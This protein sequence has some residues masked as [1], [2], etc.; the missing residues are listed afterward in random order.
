MTRLF[1]NSSFNYQEWAPSVYSMYQ[2][3]ASIK[4]NFVISTNQ[5]PQL[6]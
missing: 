2:F 3:K 4:F 1:K 6:D 5:M